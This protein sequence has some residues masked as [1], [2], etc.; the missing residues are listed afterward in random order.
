MQISWRQY[1]RRQFTKAPRHTKVGIGFGADA[2]YASVVKGKASE[3]QW[4]EQQSF[5]LKGWGRNLA[6]W[7]SEQKLSGAECRVT[8]GISHYSLL[9]VDKPAVSEEEV[10]AALQWSIQD[11]T[12][13]TGDIVVDYAD[14]PTE[15]AGQKKVNVVAVEAASIAKISRRVFDA[16]LTLASI[17]VEELSTAD[18]L[19]QS[20]Q[21]TL[22]LVQEAGQEIC[23]NIYKDN[24]LYFSRRLKGYENLGSFSEQELQMGML[25]SLGVQLQRSMDYFESQ[26]RQAPVR[27]ILTRLDSKQGAVIN[28]QL[29]QL[30]QI[31]VDFLSPDV[32]TSGDLSFQHASYLAL[33]AAMGEELNSA[34][35]G[36]NV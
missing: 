25:D 18:L 27:Q 30:T 6:N 16:G 11:L 3:K 26:L 20:E 10:A 13:L 28:E 36:G 1:L 9:Q 8:L 24:N 35:S 34:G 4:V 23:L 22:T 17:G 33:G 21:A 29:A 5:A 31:N 15:V 12:E 14:L 19:P 2:V 32:V 7:V